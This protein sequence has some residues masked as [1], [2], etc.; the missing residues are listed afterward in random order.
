[1]HAYAGPGLKSSLCLQMCLSEHYRDV[2]MSAMA[3]Q[4]TSLT[5][6]YSTVYSGADQR[7]HQR[8]AL[9]AFVRGIQRWPVNSSHKGPVTR[10]MFLFHDV[11]MGMKNSSDSLPNSNVH[12]TNEG[13]GLVAPVRPY[14][15]CFLRHI[16]WPETFTAPTYSRA[17]YRS[18]PSQW[19]RALLCN[20]VS[21]WLGAS[22]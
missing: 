15:S 8:S 4:I 21:H 13:P 1:M 18:A 16:I 11:I 12:R 5:I 6:V 9:L 22:L 20:E 10:K 14:E 19:D 3:S 17:Q 7:K 2:I